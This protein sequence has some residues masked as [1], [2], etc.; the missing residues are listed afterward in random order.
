VY[1][2]RR[3]STEGD[4]WFEVVYEDMPR[5]K[6]MKAKLSKMCAAYEKAFK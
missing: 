1:L 3:E 4:R 6:R 5:R 2:V